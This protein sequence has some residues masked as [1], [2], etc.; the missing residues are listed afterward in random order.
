MPLLRPILHPT[1]LLPHIRLP[2]PLKRNGIP[3]RLLNSGSAP[4][5]VNDLRPSF[6]APPPPPQKKPRS[7]FIYIWGTT[8]VFFGLVAGHVARSFVAPPPFPDPE[9]REDR[10]RLEVLRRDIDSLDIVKALRAEGYHLHSDTALNDSGAGKSGWRELD[11]LVISDPSG[12]KLEDASQTISNEQMLKPE[13][14]RT[15]TQKTM[16]G[17]GGLG[18]QRAFWN[19]V[20]REL[21][22][23]VFFGG[24]LSGWPG[25]AHGGAIAT[26]LQDGLSRVVAGP[27]AI[28]DSV[29]S[30]SSLSL[31]YARPTQANNFYVLRAL[32]SSPSDGKTLPPHSDPDAS[33]SWLPWSKDFTKRQ[34]VSSTIEPVVEA[35]GTIENMAGQVCVR[36][37]ASFPASAVRE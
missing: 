28:L 9:S 29:P 17:S 10:F 33:K 25:L 8:F 4:T 6:E 19:P 12:T 1:P 15:L 35:S 36:A 24:R 2:S 32:L 27:D 26:V 34:P 31:T 7:L 16:A 18:V 21:I 23:V 5:N 13:P 37:K 14:T 11:F 22:A 30:P 3:Q 20:T